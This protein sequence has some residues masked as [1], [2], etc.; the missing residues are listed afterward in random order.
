MLLLLLG[1][2]IAPALPLSPCIAFTR[3]VIFARPGGGVDLCSSEVGPSNE[4]AGVKVAKSDFDSCMDEQRTKVSLRM[5]K[6]S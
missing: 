4:K 6:Y 5:K 1:C 3:E 2:A